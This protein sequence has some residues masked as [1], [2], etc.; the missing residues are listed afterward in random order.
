[1]K[2]GQQHIYYLLAPG[3]AAAKASPHLE[4]FRKKGI[5]VLLLGDGEGIDNWV[6]ASLR[7]SS[8]ASACSRS[9]RAAAT[10]PSWRT[11]PKREAKRAGQRRARRAGRPA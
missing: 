4:A 11:R 9:P 5:E 8:T 3:L 2:E 6:V 10:C 1:M 7:E